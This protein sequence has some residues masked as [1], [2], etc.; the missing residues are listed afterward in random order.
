MVMRTDKWLTGSGLAILALVFALQGRA[1]GP[2]PEPLLRPE[3]RPA[4]Q[5]QALP[6]AIAPIAIPAPPRRP[7]PA[8]LSL[9]GTLAQDPPRPRPASAP[10]QPDTDTTSPEAAA[11]PGNDVGPTGGV[12]GGADTPGVPAP[13]PRP[14][15]P[16]DGPDGAARG[17]APVT[18]TAAPEPDV[19]ERADIALRIETPVAST[20]RPEARPGSLTESL[21]V[22]P[23][24]LAPATPAAALAAA[25]REAQT[26][27]NGR[28]APGLNAA[29]GGQ[30]AGSRLVLAAVAD[31]ARLD[32]GS[33]VRPP[34]RPRAIEAWPPESVSVSTS[35]VSA[36]AVAASLRP[37]PRSD[38]AA[39]R[40][41][42]RVAAPAPQPPRA[43]TTGRPSGQLCGVPGIEGVA[44]PRITSR[45]AGCGVAEPVRVTSVDGVRLSQP[46]V[47]DC[48]TAR[49]LHRWVREGAKPAVGRTGGGIRELHVV[50]HYVCRTRNHRPGARVSEHGRGRAIDIAAIRLADGSEMNVLRHWRN[51]RHSAALRQM[52]R[53]ACGIFGTTLGPGSDG[54]HEDHFHYDTAQHRGGPYCR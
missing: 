2:A 49:A 51:H 11:N 3:P 26:A 28:I 35:A 10:S 12:E 36:L 45:V 33:M 46:A 7:S 34:E 52:H 38:R 50:A 48:R 6:D 47:V 30:G 22:D 23:A 4:P 5:F 43:T 15:G 14:P 40:F 8:A 37:H 53:G 31:W 29:W 24:A 32:P 13:R 17:N 54:M 41:L 20:P 39:Q 9:R 42:Q 18:R 25:V 44:I 21:P 16:A 19:V 27:A 1:E